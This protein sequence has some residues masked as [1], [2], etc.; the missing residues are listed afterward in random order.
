MSS[1]S[2][3]IIFLLQIYYILLICYLVNNVFFICFLFYAL[4]LKLIKL[5]YDLYIY[6]VIVVH[7][8]KTVSYFR[9]FYHI[10]VISFNNNIFLILLQV[11]SNILQTIL[12]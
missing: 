7:K 3:I 5:S 1:Y 9:G 2:S 4:S 8:Q 11:Y 10:V 6:I 12:K